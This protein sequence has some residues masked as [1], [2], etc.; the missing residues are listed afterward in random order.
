[1]VYTPPGNTVIDANNASLIT[2]AGGGTL[3][4]DGIAQWFWTGT[5]GGNMIG[6]FPVFAPPTGE[7]T[8]SC[9]LMGG[10]GTF[11]RS[12]PV[13]SAGTMIY[14]AGIQPCE[15]VKCEIRGTDTSYP[16]KYTQTWNHTCDS[17]TSSSQYMT[18]KSRLS[19][20]N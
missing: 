10:S 3:L 5:A 9:Q 17:A 8:A 6:M 7:I 20:G 12:F 4:F 1:M 14:T 18:L 19:F 2:A 11:Q 15:I 16:F 13:P